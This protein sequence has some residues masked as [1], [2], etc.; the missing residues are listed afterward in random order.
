MH[1]SAFKEDR[2]MF[3]NL[4]RFGRPSTFL[5][6]KNINEVKDMIMENCHS[7][8]SEMSQVLN[9]SYKFVCIESLCYFIEEAP[10]SPDMT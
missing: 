7:N 6:D 3:E 2:Q 8:L 9:M 5:P 1:I 10:F 4:P